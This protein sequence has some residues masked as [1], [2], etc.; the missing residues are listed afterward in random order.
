[1]LPAHGHKLCCLVATRHV[2]L[3]KPRKTIFFL[4]PYFQN[5]VVI[6][7]NLPPLAIPNSALWNVPTRFSN[8]H[9][10]LI[11]KYLYDSESKPIPTSTRSPV[12]FPQQARQQPVP[13]LKISLF[14]IC[15]VSGIIG[16]V[17]F[18]VWLLS[19]DLMSPGFLHVSCVSTSFLFMPE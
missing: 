18:R 11:P 6:R 15:H 9:H 17:T 3:S 2:Q 4:F 7:C 12:P 19:S 1:M 10:Y 13:F 8:Q 16:N 5:I 14:W